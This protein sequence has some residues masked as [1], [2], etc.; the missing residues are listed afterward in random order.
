MICGPTGPTHR[1]SWP[2]RGGEEPEQSTGR[3]RNS[4]LQSWPRGPQWGQGLGRR[5]S[6][7]AGRRAVCLMLPAL[8]RAASVLLH[9]YGKD[10][11]AWAGGC[12]QKAN[13]RLGSQ[14]RGLLET[15]LLVWDDPEYSVHPDLPPTQMSASTSPEGSVE[16]GGC[17]MA[18]VSS[19]LLTKGQAGPFGGQI[20]G[21]GRTG[22]PWR[23]GG[24]DATAVSP[25]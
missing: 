13:A 1:S 25:G 12:E 10:S 2:P 7:L 11:P 18:C 21:L 5:G 22:M 9:N 14:E 16:P 15:A 23:E 4:T 8:L 20:M 24:P 3:G 6:P 19:R 17:V